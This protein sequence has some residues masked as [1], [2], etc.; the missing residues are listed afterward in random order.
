[1]GS[2]VRCTEY[3]NIAPHF[4]GQK[5]EALCL[6]KI[7]IQTG[8]FGSQLHKEDYVIDGTPII[9]VEH[10]A[11]NRISHENLP[12]VSD[13]DKNRLSKYHLQTGDIVFSRVGSVDRNALI[14]PY[15][16]GWLFSGRC[17]R[18]RVDQ[19]QI[20]ST[21][22]SYFFSHEGFKEHIRS[23]AVGATMPSIN[24]KILS[25]VIIY[26]PPLPEQQA[27][28]HIL[29][30][31]DDK[32]ELNRRMNATLEGMAQALFK[33]W[34]V[35]FD[36]VID[37]ALAAGNPIPEELTERAEV[38]RQALA[39]GTANREAAKQF[40]AAFQLAEE[41]GWIPEG[42]ACKQ[43]GDIAKLEYGKSLTGYRD[44]EG[45]IPVFGTNGA[46]GLTDKA[47]C[48][49]DGIVIGR[50]GAYRGVHY[51]SVPFYVI[52]TAFYLVPKSCVSKK[53]AYYE[54]LRF[55]INGMDSGSAIPSTSRD[56][57]YSLWSTLPAPIAQTEFDRIV[58]SFYERKAS[59]NKVNASLTNLRDTLLPKL[60]SGELR[61]PEAEKLTEEVRV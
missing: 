28:A 10:L 40:P 4:T 61:I 14:G 24:T 50:K 19:S 33:S 51:S 44:G 15:E 38:R 3:G 27:I 54:I 9:T 48:N 31:L 25:D 39:D 2:D 37:N 30:S 52:D 16:D 58:S 26:F 36:P 55:D 34:F 45:T 8:P 11:G 13:Q 35:D 41:L 17:L 22:L 43:W 18:V 56:D 6:K 20:S 59:N 53:W 23:V 46:I 5:L 42:W 47:I 49:S 29:G 32:I 1:M 60:I 21:Y 57:F 7:G 12:L